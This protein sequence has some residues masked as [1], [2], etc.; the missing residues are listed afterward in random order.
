MTVYVDDE[1][2]AWNGKV[3]C[4]MVA[5]TPHELHA[6]AARL[7]LKRTWFQSA[8]VYPHYDVT[9][10]VRSKALHLGAVLA[11]R[12]TLMACAKRMKLL[13]ADEAACIASST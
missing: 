4:H 8:S 9:L 1:Q 2:L 10:P 12:P 7:G 13:L 11:D 3:W 6:F 5:D